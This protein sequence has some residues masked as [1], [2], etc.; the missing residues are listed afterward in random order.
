MKSKLHN[1]YKETGGSFKRYRSVLGH[2]C[3][4]NSPLPFLEITVKDWSKKANPMTEEL[5]KKLQPTN[6]IEINFKAGN[7]LRGICA[8]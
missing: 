1:R 8:F 3:L 7:H 5:M 4:H 2:C 6:P